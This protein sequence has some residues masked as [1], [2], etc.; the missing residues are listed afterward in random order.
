M[1]IGMTLFPDHDEKQLE[2]GDRLDRMG[3]TGRQPHHLARGD[4]VHDAGDG[5]L[6]FALDHQEEGVER[7]G[8]FAQ[9]LALIEG[10]GGNGTGGPLEYGPTHHGTGLV[11]H[12]FAE[13][14]DAL[15]GPVGPGF[16][17]HDAVLSRGQV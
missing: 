9:A 12:E 17:S 1:G 15:E 5:N 13:A 3:L 7:G 11:Y 4:P 16:A 8:M 6:R 14:D 2:P 10:E